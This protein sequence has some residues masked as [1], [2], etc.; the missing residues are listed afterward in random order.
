MG[1]TIQQGM[2]KQT[3]QLQRGLQMI[4]CYAISRHNMI[5]RLQVVILD[6]CVL[7]FRLGGKGFQSSSNGFEFIGVAILR[8]KG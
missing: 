1:M 3:A 2:K 4:Q 8:K 5:T 7:R 6:G